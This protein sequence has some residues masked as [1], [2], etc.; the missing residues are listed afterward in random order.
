MNEEFMAEA[1]SLSINK[2]QANEG[3]P[4]GAVVVRNGEI[5]SRGWNRVTSTNDPTAHAEI[6]AIRE[7]CTVSGNV[8]KYLV[9]GID[10]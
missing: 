10:L 2:M 7:A 9:A 3:G 8:L 4:F 1:I 5:I 6:V